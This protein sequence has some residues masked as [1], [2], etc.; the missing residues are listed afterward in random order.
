MV[1]DNPYTGRIYVPTLDGDEP[2][3]VLDVPAL[4]YGPPQIAY[5][6]G[7]YLTYGGGR[8]SRPRFKSGG[9]ALKYFTPPKVANPKPK[10]KQPSYWTHPQTGFTARQY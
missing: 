6:K 2:L 7:Q 5:G 9:E 1:V 4:V 8:E 3:D 10:P